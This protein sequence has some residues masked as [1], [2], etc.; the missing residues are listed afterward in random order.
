M[1]S[2][3]M[4]AVLAEDADDPIGSGQTPVAWDVCRAESGQAGRPWQGGKIGGVASE[5]LALSAWRLPVSIEVQKPRIR[6]SGR[7]TPEQFSE[8]DRFSNRAATHAEPTEFRARQQSFSHPQLGLC[9]TVH[10]D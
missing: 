9:R 3:G 1:Q 10:S 4:G 2:N 6:L 5:R 7:T 8:S